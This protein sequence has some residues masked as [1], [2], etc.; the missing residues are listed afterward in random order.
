MVKGGCLTLGVAN[1][2][3]AINF[4]VETLG[5]KL[6][7]RVG[8]EWAV[9]DAGG[10]LIIGLTTRRKGEGPDGTVGLWTNEP[11]DTAVETLKGQGVSFDGPVIQ[12][13]MVRLALFRDP[14]G[15]RLSLTNVPPSPTGV[16]SGAT[17]GDRLPFFD[18][19]GLRWPSLGEDGASVEIDIRD[20]MRG[21]AGTLQGG[22]I[23]TLIDV[24]AAA[25]AAQGS[26]GLVATSEMSVHFLAPGRIGPV[27]ADGELLRSR[28]GGAAVE[29]RVY[30]TGNHDRLMAVSLAAFA[31]LAGAVRSQASSGGQPTDR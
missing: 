16:T 8:D 4:Y 9:I 1:F 2:D 30:D 27:R 25:T 6:M 19:L 7:M 23:A 29:V 31:D 28:S 20:D 3:V 5:L 26:G 12:E 13:G 10:G 14:D 17:D 18:H 22:I 21:P 11:L 15:N 24:A